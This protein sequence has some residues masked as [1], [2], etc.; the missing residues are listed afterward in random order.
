MIKS[1]QYD[2]VGAFHYCSKQGGGGPWGPLV[3][4]LTFLPHN[5]SCELSLLSL[6]ANKLKIFYGTI[7]FIYTCQHSFNWHSANYNQTT[8]MEKKHGKISYCCA[9][10]CIANMSLGMTDHTTFKSYH[11][12]AAIYYWWRE[13][14]N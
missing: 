13:W 8:Y 5:T 7:L 12:G 3:I 1:L 2:N 14:E 6:S 10:M 11:K 9:K 4:L